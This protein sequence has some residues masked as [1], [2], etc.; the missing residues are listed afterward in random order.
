[1]PRGLLF[2]FLCRIGVRMRARGS[3]WAR[4]TIVVFNK[5]APDS[6]G[7]AKFYAQQRS[8]PQDQIVGLSCSTAEEISR[9]EYDADIAEPLRKIFKDRGWWTLRDAPDNKQVVAS[10]KIYF[11]ALIKGMPLK[12]RSTTETY[13]GDQWGP[14]PI[15]THNEACVDSEL[16][17]LPFFFQANLRHYSKPVLSEFSADLR[18]RRNCATAGLSP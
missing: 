8:I 1:M 2:L 3:G 9:D 18:I 16:S 6:A 4:A 10:R 7:L 5:T 11:V 13:V 14:G 12:I 15:A 17:T